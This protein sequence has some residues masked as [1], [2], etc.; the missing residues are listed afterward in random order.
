MHA[1]NPQDSILLVLVSYRTARAAKRQ[2]RRFSP[3]W[4]GSNANWDDP[5][6]WSGCPNGCDPNDAEGMTFNATI[7][8]GTVALD[9]DIAIQR[10]FFNG[11]IHGGKITGGSQLTLNEG[12]TWNGGEIALGAGGVNQ[13]PSWLD[14][15]CS[16]ARSDPTRN[17]LRARS[18]TPV[19]LRWL[20]LPLF[21]GPMESSTIW[22]ESKLDDAERIVAG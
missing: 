22:P 5:L 15:Q 6:Q 19:V 1:T 3:V 2:F 17:L 21:L 12:F 13:P 20:R 7:N 9:R 4:N 14:L 16:R 8:S 10:L 18:M 11:N